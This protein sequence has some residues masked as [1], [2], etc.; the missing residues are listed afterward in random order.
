MVYLLAALCA[1]LLAAVVG[2]GIY[3]IRT[4]NAR[5]QRGL[6]GPW[7]IR[8]V[9]LD[10]FDPVFKC[11]P[12]GPHV[13]TQVRFLGRG[14]LPVPGGTSDVESW[15]LAVLAKRSTRLFEFGTCTGKTTWLWAANSP[16]DAKVTTLT[17][18]PEQVGDYSPDDAD[19]PQAATAAAE[20]SRFSRFVYTGTAEEDKIEQLYGDSKAFDETAYRGACDLVFIDGS[21]AYSYVRSDTEKALAMV[22]PG[23]IILWH[24]YHGPRRATGVWRALNELN[25]RLPLVHLADASLVAYRHREDE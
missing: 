17:L 22:R 11:G 24:D 7:P 23:G 20:E 25:E 16:A 9:A 15:I 2:M 12:L 18:A 13:D 8:R 3:V 10:Q 19:D 4:R 5:K 21:H 14:N 6:F 1:L